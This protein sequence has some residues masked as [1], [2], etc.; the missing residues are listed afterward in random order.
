MVT[1]EGDFAG[2]IDKDETSGLSK[3]VLTTGMHDDVDGNVPL[4]PSE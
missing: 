1:F 3:G 4:A 2:L